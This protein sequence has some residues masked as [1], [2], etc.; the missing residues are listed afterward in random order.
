MKNDSVRFEFTTHSEIDY[1]SVKFVFKKTDTMPYVVQLTD[2]KD[3]YVFREFKC[4]DDTTVEFSNLDPRVYKLK[5]IRDG[6]GNGKWDTGD[7][8]NH[9]QPEEIEFYQEGITVRA[10]W[11]VEL[12]I[13]APLSAGR[14]QK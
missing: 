4:S 6:N 2:D 12:F 7:Y 8:L 10:N 11:D 5:L 3:K 13:Q 9:V 1:C 14:I